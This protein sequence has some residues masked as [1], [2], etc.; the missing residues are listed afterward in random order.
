MFTGRV[1]GREADVES[2]PPV[3]KILFEHTLSV[4]PTRYIHTSESRSNAMGTFCSRTKHFVRFLRRLEL[5]ESLEYNAGTQTTIAIVYASLLSS[6]AT[7]KGLVTRKSSLCG[8]MDAVAQ[9]S[10]EACGRDITLDPDP[11]TDPLNWKKHRMI[12]YIEQ[13]QKKTER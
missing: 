9:Y 4:A 1:V 10:I 8:Y 3:A 7:I 11:K 2:L 6:G 13:Y 12:S 5:D